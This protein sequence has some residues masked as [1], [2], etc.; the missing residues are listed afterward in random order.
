[1]VSEQEQILRWFYRQVFPSG[2]LEFSDQLALATRQA[3]GKSE[4][5]TESYVY[6]S[7]NRHWNSFIKRLDDDRSL[8]R[9]A[10]F[11]IRDITS[12]R[13]SWIPNN[14]SALESVKERHMAA[15]LG[16]APDI[17]ARIDE[18]SA[19]EYEALGCVV[20][21]L[22]GAVHVCLTPSGND[23]GIDFF[24][25][26]NT[27]ARCHIF[28]GNCNPLRIIGQAKKYTDAV[29]LDQVKEFIASINYIKYQNRDIEDLVPVWFWEASGPIAGWI[30]AHNGLERGA[31]DKARNH[32]IIVSDSVDLAEIAALSRQIDDRLSCEQRAES[33]CSRV[34]KRL[35]DD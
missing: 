5:D 6:S 21:E 2:V 4:M 7:L 31:G 1:M 23:A 17:L 22:A 27:P 20:S 3:L 19:R 24:A 18:L 26:I 25:L 14:I 9:P 32:G 33:V 28:S 16:S 29:G 15:R 34:A 30:V 10:L 11:M 35:E 8:G 12:R 13:F